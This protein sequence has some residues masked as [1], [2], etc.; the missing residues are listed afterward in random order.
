MKLGCFYLLVIVN[1]AAAVIIAVQVSIW[2]TAFNSSEYIY[3]EVE[4]LITWKFYF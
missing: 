1:N 3:L 4:L 2:A